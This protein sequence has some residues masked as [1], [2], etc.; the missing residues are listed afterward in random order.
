MVTSPHVAGARRNAM[1]M[2]G[3]AVAAGLLMLY[4]TSTNSQGATRKPGQAAAK[5]GVVVP[6]PA[7]SAPAAPTEVVVNGTSVDTQYG[8][9]QVQIRVRA[10]HLVSAKAIDY[11]TGSGRDREI[12]SQAIPILQQETVQAGNAQIDSVSG[13][14]YTSEGYRQSLQSALDLAHLG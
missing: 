14:T 6:P 8:P 9:V 10:G 13:A 2:A 5:A 1:V 12:N 3:T 11:P 7:A 4:P